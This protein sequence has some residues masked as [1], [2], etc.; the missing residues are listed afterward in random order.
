[1]YDTC[2]DKWGLGDMSISYMKE[3]NLLLDELE[4]RPAREIAPTMG[5][6]QKVRYSHSAMVDAII[7]NPSISQNQ[8]ADIFGFTPGWV[9]N[10]IASDAFQAHL[11]Q[12]KDELIDPTLRL[13]IEE[14]FKALVQR[15]LEVL[16]EKLAKPTHTIPD[17]LALQA[18]S[19]GA[20]SLGLGRADNNAPPPQGGDRLQ[21]LASRMIILQREVKNGQ[22]IEGVSE[23]VYDS[24]G[25]EEGGGSEPG[26]G[27]S[28]E[29]AVR[30]IDSVSG[31]SA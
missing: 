30:A 28:A 2:G 6:L 16:Q 15:S 24:G 7:E 25:R 14:R 13:S 31:E 3:A 9:S 11:A 1:M 5:R 19:L 23:T 20:R 8:L 17:Q 27:Q 26:Q 4:G 18:A 12:R 22:V 10:V 21:I 29:G